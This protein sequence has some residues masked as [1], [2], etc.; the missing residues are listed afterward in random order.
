MRLLVHI[1]VHFFWVC[2]KKDA[3]AWVTSAWVHAVEH[4]P[5]MVVQ[6]TP[7]SERMSVL[8]APR[9]CQNEVLLVFFSQFFNLDRDTCRVVSCCG[10][11]WHSLDD[12]EVAHLFT[13]LSTI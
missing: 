11:N 6:F 5:R 12:Y 8:V 7:H 9:P 13:C 10:C 4:F 3:K 2:N 1:R